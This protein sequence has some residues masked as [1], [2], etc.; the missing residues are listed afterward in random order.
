MDARLAY[1]PESKIQH[2]R[3]PWEGKRVI[4]AALQHLLLLLSDS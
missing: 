1:L 4:E 2:R 3:S